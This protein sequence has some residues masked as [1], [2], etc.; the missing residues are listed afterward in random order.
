MATV[1]GSILDQIDAIG[2]IEPQ[3]SPG[4]RKDQRTIDDVPFNGRQD[5]PDLVEVVR[6]ECSAAA[7]E[8]VVDRLVLALSLPEQW[9]ERHLLAEIPAQVEIAAGIVDVKDPRVNTAAE[10]GR[11]A[12]QLL[13]V[14][15]AC[16]LLLCP[17]CGLGRR[18][19]ELACQSH[20]HDRGCE[21]D[22]TSL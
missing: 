13:T 7:L 9:A 12:E 17:S 1:L 5:L 8:G 2:G 18:T 11:F 22:L 15:P 19:V 3:G 6:V 20:S 4:V 21:I 10:P 16:R 14:V